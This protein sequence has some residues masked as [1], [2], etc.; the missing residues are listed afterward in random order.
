M[1]FNGLPEVF[2]D[3][4]QNAELYMQKRIYDSLQFLSILPMEQNETGL[5]SN[6]IH[7][8]VDVGKPMY[9][10]NGITFNEIKF[11]QGKTV[12]GQ[13]LPNGYMYNAST[14][15]KQKGTYE[16]DLLSF[17]N[18]SVVQFA[19]FY[20]EEFAK[21]ILKGGRKSSVELNEWDTAEHIIDNELTLDDEMRYD[22]KDNRTGFA[23]NTAIVS[24][25]TK[26]DI[27]QALRVEKYESNWNYISSNRVPDGKFA[28]FDSFNPGANIQKYADPD[29]SIVQSL[30]D[31]GIDIP[32]EDGE[33]IPKA[34]MNVDVRSDKRPQNEEHYVWAE[35]NLNMRDSNGFLIVTGE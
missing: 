16:S 11:G 24:R 2:E 31:N 30:E 27:E 15:N 3:R 25:K 28:I 13:T 9:T 29:Y 6:Y 5:F 21:S 18:A 7:G 32:T 1:V 22:S 20:E 17:Y 10:N 14:R 23:P 4:V 8:D 33:P 34:F 26:L 12:G 19:D 35:A